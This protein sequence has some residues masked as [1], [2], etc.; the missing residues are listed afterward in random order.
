MDDVNWI[1]SIKTKHSAVEGK[2]KGVTSPP[3]RLYNICHSV[4]LSGLNQI[5]YS[6]T[7]PLRPTNNHNKQIEQIEQDDETNERD[8]PTVP[9]I[10]LHSTQSLSSAFKR[11][12]D[13]TLDRLLSPRVPAL[14]DAILRYGL[15]DPMNEYHTKNRVKRSALA[16]LQN[17]RIEERKTGQ[18]STAFNLCG[19][20]SS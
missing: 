18:D 17:M 19:E 12:K 1:I 6:N 4:T 8:P 15:S 13:S 7:Y 11:G 2:C 10:L 3:A 14:I 20:H 9:S 16:Y 5:R